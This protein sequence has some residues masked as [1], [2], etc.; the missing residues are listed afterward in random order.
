MRAI[1]GC[2]WD[3]PWSWTRRNSAKVTEAGMTLMPF[4]VDLSFQL[5]V[6]TYWFLNIF[7]K[8]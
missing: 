2:D 4:H 3:C 5:L 1:T 6:N 7:V 8:N